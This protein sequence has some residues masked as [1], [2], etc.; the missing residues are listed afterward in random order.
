MIIFVVY[1]TVIVDSK[2][3]FQF[4]DSFEQYDDAKEAA[5]SEPNTIVIPFD[6]DDGDEET[7]YED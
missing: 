3:T 7:Y 2:L 6:D 5:E 1:K 4:M